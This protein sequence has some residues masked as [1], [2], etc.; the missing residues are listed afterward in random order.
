MQIRAKTVYRSA[1][2]WVVTGLFAAANLWSWMR[3]VSNPLCCD[4][5][6]TIGF[7]VPFHISGGIAGTASFYLLGLL[8]DLAIVV[9]VALTATWIAQMFRRV[10]RS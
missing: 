5:E 10:I 1:T 4:Q 3:H 6:A 7:P 9:T 2:F 8:L